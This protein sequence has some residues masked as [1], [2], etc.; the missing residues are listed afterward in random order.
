MTNVTLFDQIDRTDASGQGRTERDFDFLNRR[1][2]PMFQ[3]RRNMLESWF[4]K[5]PDQKERDVKNKSRLREMFRGDNGPH[6]GV[7][8]ELLIHELLNTIG[9][10][11]CVHP[12]TPDF[13]ATINGVRIL[14]E[15]TVLQDLDEQ[16]SADKREA[17]IKKVV[18][19]INTGGFTLQWQC[20]AQGPQQPSTTN[21][22]RRIKNWISTLDPSEG[23]IS[24]LE[25]SHEGWEVIVKALPYKPGINKQEGDR[26]IGLETHIEIINGGQFQPALEKKAKKYNSSELP[27]VVVATKNADWVYEHSIWENRMIDALYGEEILLHK[28]RTFDGLFG[29]PENPKH[30][31]VSAILFKRELSLAKPP[32]IRDPDMPSWVLY[33]HPGAKRPLSPALF[34]F[35][36]SVDLTKTPEVVDAT[37][38]LRDLLG[39]PPDIATDMFPIEGGMWQAIV[40]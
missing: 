30:R 25:W 18:D 16:V 21:L 23:K 39:L 5:I 29:S 4:V 3:N 6:L 22:K 11:V 2:H 32:V 34:P 33:H 31:G 36:A 8:F 12:D 14:L 10:E 9:T 35:A 37:C 1:A 15:C 24:E 7:F 20:L 27:Y 38:T 17:V 13:S 28:G 19:S 26:A 40:G